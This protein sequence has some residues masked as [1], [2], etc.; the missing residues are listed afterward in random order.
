LSCS[1]GSRAVES[2]PKTL[3]VAGAGETLGK[4]ILS[5]SLGFKKW[6]FLSIN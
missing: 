6:E 4:S 1:K 5:V 3:V 2:S